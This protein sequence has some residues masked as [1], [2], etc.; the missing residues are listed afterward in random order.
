M[1]AGSICARSFLYRKTGP[2]TG[3]ARRE[4]TSLVM[5]VALADK[6]AS[7]V[8]TRLTDG[9]RCSAR[10]L[11]RAGF[12]NS[13]PR[14]LARAIACDGGGGT[15]WQKTDGK[16][17]KFG[18]IEF[19]GGGRT[20]ARISA[21]L[22]KSRL[23]HTRYRKRRPRPTIYISRVSFQLDHR[24]FFA[25]EISDFSPCIRGPNEAMNESAHHSVLQ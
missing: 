11:G 12:S 23:G 21:Q 17:F 3:Y 16:A 10:R 6:A 24:R 2:V 20:S 7:G 14:V 15:P 1:I 22:N 18:P 19:R 5:A 8:P 4:I 25:L 9:L 13:S